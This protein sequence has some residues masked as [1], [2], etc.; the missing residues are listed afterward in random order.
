[1]KKWIF[2]IGIIIIMAGCAA[3]GYLFSE[4]G[5][6]LTDSPEAETVIAEMSESDAQFTETI[7]QYVSKEYAESV[8]EQMKTDLPGS[9][10]P[11]AVT[12]ET[13]VVP[14]QPK[15]AS[16]TQVKSPSYNSDTKVT[17]KPLQG[18]LIRKHIDELLSVKSTFDNKLQALIEK[19]KQEFIALPPEARTTDNKIKIGLK[20]MDQTLSLENQADA[21]IYGVISH[22]ELELKKYNYETSVIE[23]IKKY[24]EQQKELQRTYYMSKLKS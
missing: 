23:E 21:E 20:Y 9:E 10:A 19:A 15:A 7:E 4:Y 8:A 6:L 11:A 24:Y 18:D 1:M 14:V 17:G 12:G 5:K 3:A 13:T 16:A 2:K 22:L